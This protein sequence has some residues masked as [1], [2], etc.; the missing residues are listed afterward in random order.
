MLTLITKYLGLG[1]LVL[2][3]SVAAPAHAD[4]TPDQLTRKTTEDVMAIL[5]KDGDIRNGNLEKAYALIEAKILPH[6]DFD[7][8]T[9]S[10]VGKYWGR[11]TPAQK[12]QLV[13]AFKSLLVRIYATSLTA[14]SNQ[15]V[16]FK[17]FLMNPGDTD[18]SVRTEVRQAGNVPPV[19]IN[20]SFYKTPFGWKVYDVSVDGVSLVGNY[21][22]RFSKTIKDAGIDGLIKSMN[23][24]AAQ[25][26]K[27][28]K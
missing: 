17:P 5:K 25:A 12:Q 16:V 6:F 14:F 19:P 7:N 20:Y 15:E 27:A 18:V 9:Q 23:S 2:M 3:F 11:A 24:Q 22:A 1:A 26:A 8:M 21:R 4:E 10:A 13:K 28:G